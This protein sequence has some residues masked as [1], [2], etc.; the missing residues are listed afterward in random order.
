MKE[1]R[2]M[3]CLKSKSRKLVLLLLFIYIFNVFFAA[4]IF[5]LNSSNLLMSER[6]MASKK[7]EKCKKYFELNSQKWYGEF[8][9][10]E[11]DSFKVVSEKEDI[12]TQYSTYYRESD[13]ES[14]SMTS[15][16][17]IAIGYEDNVPKNY[18]SSFDGSNQLILNS[19]LK[20]FSFVEYKLDMTSIGDEW[21]QYYSDIYFNNF[22]YYSVIYLGEDTFTSKVYETSQNELIVDS[23]K[24]YYCVTIEFGK[25][26]KKSC[27]YLLLEKDIMGDIWFKVL[28]DKYNKGD[29]Y[30]L[31]DSLVLYKLINHVYEESGEGVSDIGSATT[32]VTIGEKSFLT[33]LISKNIF[34]QDGMPN[35]NPEQAQINYIDCCFLSLMF[36]T[37]TGYS[38][39]SLDGAFLQICAGIEA[40]IQ[41]GLILAMI[42]NILASAVFD[43]GQ[44]ETDLHNAEQI[45]QE[46]GL[47][48]VKEIQKDAICDN[49]IKTYDVN[50]AEDGKIIKKYLINCKRK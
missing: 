42:V 46:K 33:T 49:V 26:K 6:L 41:N 20:P 1:F 29:V 10:I 3:F 22:E 13:L 47:Q 34:F 28:E 35:F 11:P 36:A 21:A 38:D 9:V 7:V 48:G 40:V 37:T 12:S 8:L 32:D 2:E 4:G 24:E 15:T 23:E 44:Q 19:W 43:K 39:I 5:Y 45:Q 18:A 17:R 16:Y 27:M 14:T 50:V 31:K 30:Y 25:G